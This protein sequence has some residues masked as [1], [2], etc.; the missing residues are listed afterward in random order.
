MAEDAMP[1]DVAMF[2]DDIEQP[3]MD[4]VKDF[5]TSHKVNT[6]VLAT[7]DT[8]VC[9]AGEFEIAGTCEICPAGYMS[10]TDS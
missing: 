2:M 9:E 1:A 6:P 7:W 4:E 5:V 8:L 10:F 3:Q